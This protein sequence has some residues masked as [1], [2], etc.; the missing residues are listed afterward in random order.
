MKIVM[1]GMPGSGKGTQSQ[2]I[3]QRYNIPTISTGELIRKCEDKELKEIISR[4]CLIDD[5][6]MLKMIYNA[7][8]TDSF[9]LDGFPR[10]LKQAQMI[11]VDVAVSI[12]LSEDEAVKRLL[13][14]GENREDDNEEV[15]R[16]RFRI[17]HKETEPLL[18][19]YRQQ[20]I[21]KEVNGCGAKEEVYEA[22]CA[23]LQDLKIKI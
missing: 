7:V 20:G 16:N 2:L 1:I 23:N 5:N 6:T 17:Y 15:I 8:K 9:I 19:H 22:I 14:R 18:E 12:S 10:N 13:Q 4:G 11:N 21:L 3:S